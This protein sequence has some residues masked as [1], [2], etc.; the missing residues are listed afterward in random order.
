MAEWHRVGITDLAVL[1]MDHDLTIIL[2]AT[3]SRARSIAPSWIRNWIRNRLI[4][5]WSE[6]RAAGSRP[7]PGEHYT[8]TADRSGSKEPFNVLIVLTE[9]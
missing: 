7:H 5:T 8:A 6:A 2:P 1:A 9:H 4:E 3:T